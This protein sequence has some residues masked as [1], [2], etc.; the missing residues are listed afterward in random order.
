MKMNKNQKT[1][2]PFALEFLETV[3]DLSIVT[4]SAGFTTMAVTRPKCGSKKHD[5]V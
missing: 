1:T 5:N 2:R 4:G 3:S